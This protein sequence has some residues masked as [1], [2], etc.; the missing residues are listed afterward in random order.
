MDFWKEQ[1]RGANFFTSV[2][3]TER[4]KAAKEFGL[5]VIRLAPNK[6]LNGRPE[7]ELGDFYPE[8]LVNLKLLIKTM[9]YFFEK[10]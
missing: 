4:F 1:K 9:S 8:G 5:Q 6:W 10:S 2:E 7:S 3:K